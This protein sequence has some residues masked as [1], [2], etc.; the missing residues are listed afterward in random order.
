MIYNILVAHCHWIYPSWDMWEGSK[1]SINLL[2][3]QRQHFRR[4]DRFI[5]IWKSTVIYSGAILKL[6][7]LKDNDWEQVFIVIFG[8]EQGGKMTGVQTGKISD[9]IITLNTPLSYL[10]NK[11][12]RYRHQY[13]SHTW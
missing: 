2:Q 7:V 11:T 13:Q 12:L 1:N 10:S 6:E 9:T 8:S 3:P 4:V 5:D